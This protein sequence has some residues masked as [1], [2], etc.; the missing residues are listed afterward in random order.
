[1]E[2]IIGI[3]ATLLGALYWQTQK[4][5]IAE[6]RNENILTKEK[7][8]DIN[9]EIASNSGSIESEKLKQEQLKKDLENVKPGGMSVD[10]VINI[11]NKF[12]S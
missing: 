12:K 4:R 1:M 5:K 3:I 10:D 7:L 8:N 2:Y 6:A 11:I 9:K